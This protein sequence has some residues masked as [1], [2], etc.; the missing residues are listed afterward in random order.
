M[1]QQIKERELMTNM[2]SNFYHPNLKRV[3]NHH[4]F[5]TSLKKRL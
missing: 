5:V 3:L 2:E 1:N 4:Q